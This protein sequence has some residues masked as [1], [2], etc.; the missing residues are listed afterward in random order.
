MVLDWRGVGLIDDDGSFSKRGF[1]VAAASGA[2][3]TFGRTGVLEE[4]VEVEF[5][6]LFFV[7]DVKK[8]GRLLGFGQRAGDDDGDGLAAEEDVGVLEDVDVA[9]DGEFGRVE[10]RDDGVDTGGAGGCTLI[11]GGDGSCG[12]GGLDNVGVGDVFDGEFGCVF[13]TTGDFGEAV[14]AGGCWL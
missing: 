5:G 4:G 11:D 14:V 3:S 9:G 2:A 10:R 8:L 13:G 7:L 6:G 12:D 1:G